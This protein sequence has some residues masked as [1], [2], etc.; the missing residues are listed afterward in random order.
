MAAV[1][2]G[3]GAAGAAL[4]L[5]VV[6]SSAHHLTGAAAVVALLSLDN[7]HAVAVP[8]LHALG[9]VSAVAVAAGRHG[10]RRSRSAATAS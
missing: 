8:L 2:G 7:L 6:L 10:D 9:L 3:A 1:A 4:A 5:G